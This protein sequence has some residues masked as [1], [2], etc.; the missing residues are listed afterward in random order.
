[1]DERP[2][3]STRPTEHRAT[4]GTTPQRH[5]DVLSPATVAAFSAFYRNEVG[6]L[7]AFLV[8][9]GASVADAADVA[10]ETMR[11]ALEQ[12]DTIRSP[13]PWTRRVAS[14]EYARRMAG[15]VELPTDDLADRTPLLRA[16]VSEIA[17]WEAGQEELR[18]LGHL[19]SRQRQVMAWT[20]EGYQPGEIAEQL[21]MTPEAVRSSLLKARRAL[22][23]LLRGEPDRR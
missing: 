18:L 17:A 2:G 3:G 9:Q 23:T 19:P 5:R 14:R 22:A 12:W 4:P 20:L 21:N 7:V 13:G 1:M 11:R 15:L 6:R 8:W 10:Q 16:S